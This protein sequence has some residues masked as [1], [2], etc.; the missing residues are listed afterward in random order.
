MTNL[1]YGSS[2]SLAL[3]STIKNMIKALHF[4][5]LLCEVFSEKCT[6]VPHAFPFS[7]HPF[8]LLCLWMYHSV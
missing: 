5:V 2:Y 1:K 4:F 7:V 6:A 3:A 8:I